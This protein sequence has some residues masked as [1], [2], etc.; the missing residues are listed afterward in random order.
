M[1][2]NTEQ[3]LRLPSL[4]CFWPETA[5][6]RDLLRAGCHSLDTVHKKHIEVPGHSTTVNPASLCA[7]VSMSL[8]FQPTIPGQGRC[9]LAGW[10][11]PLRLSKAVTP[12]KD[13]VCG[14]SQPRCWLPDP[15]LFRVLR[16]GS[17]CPTT[18]RSFCF[19]LFKT[20][21]HR[22]VNRME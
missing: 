7:P 18:D 2:R 9:R 19:I 17:P 3:Q 11:S 4:G 10:L 13:D 15:Q 20:M 14:R 8:P 16:W 1:V 22:A 21:A 6:Y 5:C 12:H